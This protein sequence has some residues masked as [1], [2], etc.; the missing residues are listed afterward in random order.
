MST[1]VD[2]S[3]PDVSEMRLLDLLELGTE[4]WF[5]DYKSSMDLDDAASRVEFARD[6]AAFSDQGGWLVVGADS[7]GRATDW[8]GIEA[9]WDSSVV[10][11]KVRKYLAPGYRL[12]TAIHTVR[13]F[14]YLLIQILPHEDGVCVITAP[15][16]V[17]SKNRSSVR[18]VFRKGDIFTRDEQDSVRATQESLTR[19]LNKRAKNV[20]SRESTAALARKRALEGPIS[21]KH[22]HVRKGQL[23]GQIGWATTGKPNNLTEKLFFSDT[24][25]DSFEQFMFEVLESKHLRRDGHSYENE[26]QRTADYIR[27]YGKITHSNQNPGY[28][29]VRVYRDGSI[30]V[31]FEE[32]TFDWS[33]EELLG[34]WAYGAT[35]IAY[36]IMV[37]LELEGILFSSYS[38]PVH[39]LFTKTSVRDISQYQAI[40]GGVAENEI[41][42]VNE[43]ISYI[44]SKMAEY[45]F[46][47]ADYASTDWVSRHGDMLFPRTNWASAESNSKPDRNSDGRYVPVKDRIRKILTLNK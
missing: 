2:T 11:A 5:L 10:R 20:V 47:S 12:Y 46:F 44:A 4:S 8:Q 24:R 3:R 18:T 29:D 40:N 17:H 23:C 41:S 33:T 15:G 31:Y 35:R 37:Y 39:R 7:N 25:R 21:S 9:D 42:R 22:E 32:D 6:V 36:R 45:Q 38:L 14:M 43:D 26:V 19:I 1:A 16:N 28:C 13:G 30:L 34:W 27:S